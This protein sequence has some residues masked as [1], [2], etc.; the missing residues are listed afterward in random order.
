MNILVN[1]NIQEFKKIASKAEKGVDI[2]RPVTGKD[3]G[4][5]AAIRTKKDADQFFKDLKSAVTKA[6]KSQK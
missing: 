1:K 2:V 6:K 4:L 3:D 5:S